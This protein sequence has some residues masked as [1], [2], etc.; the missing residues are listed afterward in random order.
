MVLIMLAN[1][2]LVEIPAGVEVF[3][4]DGL[5]T[6]WDF[7]GRA[8]ISWPREEVSAYTRNPLLVRAMLAGQGN[9]S[10]D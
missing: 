6:C 2:E 9:P 1:G 5:L 8:L 4:R 3:A 10:L 7:N